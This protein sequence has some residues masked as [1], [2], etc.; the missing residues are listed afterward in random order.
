MVLSINQTKII[1][2]ISDNP[3]KKTKGLSGRDFLPENQGMLFVY[4]KEDY[5]S[6]WMKNMNFPLDFIW[7]NNN[8]VVEI[9]ENVLPKDYQP[10]KIL[11]PSQKVNMVL[12]VNAGF[13]KKNNIKTGDI[14]IIDLNQH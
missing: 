1:A 5:Y 13:A 6:F 3:F 9:T 7:I 10:P 14:V 11:R 4:N 12:E 8:R 2:E